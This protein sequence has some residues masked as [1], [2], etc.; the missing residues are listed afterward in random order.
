MAKKP[1]KQSDLNE[2]ESNAPVTD[3]QASVQTKPT[4]RL[5]M[6]TQAINT[7]QQMSDDDLNGFAQMIMSIGHEADNIAPDQA[8]KN[9]A[10]IAMKEEVDK[11][12]SE[13]FGDVTLTEETKTKIS[14]LFESAV[15]VKVATEIELLKEQY[16][17]KLNEEAAVIVEQMTE[18]VDAYITYIAE[19]WVEKNQLAIESTLKAEITEDLMIDLKALFDKHNIDIPED[20]VDVV[21][22]LTNKTLALE[23]ELNDT[24]DQLIEAYSVISEVNRSTLIEEAAQGLTALQKDKF[25]KLAEG[26]EI[27]EE[28]LEILK[29]HHFSARAPIRD[30][31]II[32]ED[33]IEEGVKEK[34][35]D[36]RTSS[37]V[38]ALTALKMR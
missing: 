3:A 11:E 20:K 18:Q 6:M 1:A 29:N 32:N 34:V 10:T 12:L 5:Q 33:V 37:Y 7:I 2:D 8:M 17:E 22:E 36:E 28:K 31:K 24:K 16:D 9:A 26:I 25:R 13:I 19:Q 14:T 15:A 4:N 21:E 35:L 30:T 27:T 38:S 23:S